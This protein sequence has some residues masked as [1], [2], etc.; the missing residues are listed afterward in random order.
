MNPDD[1][2]KLDLLE[3][4]PIEGSIDAIRGE[5]ANTQSTRRQ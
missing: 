2:I 5:L 4:P 1:P 3:Y